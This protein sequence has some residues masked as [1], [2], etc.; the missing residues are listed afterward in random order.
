MATVRED[1]MPAMEEDP[2]TVRLLA[3]LPGADY[4]RLLAQLETVSLAWQQVLYEPNQPIAHIYFPHTS[5]IS[6]PVRMAE[7]RI[8]EVAMVGAEGLVGLPVFLADERPH[9][10]ALVDI[11]GEA[12][13]ISVDRFTA[14]VQQ[15]P[16]LHTL[17]H[18]YAQAL[19][20]QITQVAA[21]N[22]LHVVEARCAR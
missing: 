7:G 6:L 15:S 12:E 10:L 21:C 9:L 5:V 19:L 17:L 11:A 8:V 14:A 20:I 13:R 18:R 22:A 3:A 4:A 16:A 1:S 2:A